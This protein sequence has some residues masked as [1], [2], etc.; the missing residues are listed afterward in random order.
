ML[1]TEKGLTFRWCWGRV[2][3]VY[4]AGLGGEDFVN[5]LG[6][7]EGGVVGFDYVAVDV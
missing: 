1:A 6:D 3:G 7:L 2:L 4:F 5:Y